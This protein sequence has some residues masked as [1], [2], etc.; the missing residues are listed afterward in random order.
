MYKGP[1]PVDS[2]YRQFYYPP[3]FRITFTRPSYEMNNKIIISVIC[4]LTGCTSIHPER[5][6]PA[7]SP[8][9]NIYGEQCATHASASDPRCLQYQNTR[10]EARAFFERHTDYMNDDKKEAALFAEFSRLLNNPEYQ[11]WSLSQLLETAHRN[12]LTGHN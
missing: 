6:P 11:E 1:R 8:A 5:Q 3:L 12:I 9:A 10:K 7:L 4:L 2:L